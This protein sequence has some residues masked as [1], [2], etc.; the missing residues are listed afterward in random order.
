MNLVANS[1][2]FS[3]IIQAIAGFFLYKSLLKKIPQSDQILKT[4][5]KMELSV[6][7]LEGFFYFFIIWRLIK[8]IYDVDFRY[9]DWFITTPIMLISTM[10]FL[11]YLHK[12]PVD[13]KETFE[14]NK[15]TITGL[16]VFNALM[17]I[18][19]FLGEKGIIGKYTTFFVGTLFLVFSFLCLY[20]FAKKSE[21]GKK[22]FGV[23]FFIWILYGFA[24]LLPLAHKNISYNILDLFSK[25]FY[26]IFLYFL[27]SHK[28][29][30]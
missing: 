11:E 18:V 21:N 22:F 10:L 30:N 6:Q 17:L 13:T 23:M 25:N 27:I 5:V 12:T 7:I 28:Y 4:I 15:L 20:N 8:G 3:I 26:G 2:I 19:G 16:L 14:N 9:Y 1:A 24:F 29:K